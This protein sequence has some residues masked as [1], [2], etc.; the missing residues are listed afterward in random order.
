[1]RV[2]VVVLLSVVMGWLWNIV[3][4]VVGRERRQSR[5]AIIVLLGNEC[6]IICYCIV[7]SPRRVAH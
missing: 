2:V 6:A 4:V 3:R 1:M 7:R 5:D